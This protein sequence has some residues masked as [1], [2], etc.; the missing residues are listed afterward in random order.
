MRH[1]TVLLT[2]AL[3][4]ASV[5]TATT[6]TSSAAFTSSTTATAHVASAVD[7]TPPTASVAP[8]PAHV[9]GT[10]TVT[11]LATDG[12]TGV[13][14][15]TLEVRRAGATSWTV[16]GA[17]T[18]EPWTFVWDTSA[19]P[20]GEHELRAT[21]TDGVGLSTT[22]DVVRTT[23]ANGLSVTLASPGAVLAGTVVLA[24][25]VDGTGVETVRLEAAPAG[26]GRWDLLGTAA[27]P[28]YRV[29]VDTGALAEG[30]H[31]VRA[32]ARSLAGHETA[33][34]VTTVLV[35]NHA[36][37]AVD[38]QAADGGGT[39]GGIEPGD[40]LTFTYSEE[41][42]LATLTPGWAGDPLAVLVRVT[43]GGLVWGGPEDDVLSVR[44]LGSGVEL[45]TVAL[46]A[47][48]VGTQQVLTFRATMHATT[49]HSPAGPRTVV[50]VVLGT[51]VAGL[52][53]GTAGPGTM[54]WTPSDAPTDL[55]GTHVVPEPV[56]ESGPTDAD[57]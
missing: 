13:R 34:A 41:I 10:V 52:A 8:L 15:V 50:H 53:A 23:V 17:R 42:D 28:P 55:A 32:V 21:A 19:L 45:G 38:V 43:D 47:D 48:H 39:T 31:D 14:E 37:R 26:S 33:S 29:E 4:V 12:E 1:L 11:V 40:T 16:V 54:T 5:A 49:E 25:D 2:A 7:W 9:A 27:A 36:P 44:R 3:V 35:D 24:A 22:S 57:F 6:R 30:H 18:S 20:D 51:E 56:V 46:G